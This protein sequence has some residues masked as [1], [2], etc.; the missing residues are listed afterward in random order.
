VKQIS[1][2]PA[3]LAAT[4]FAL[5]CAECGGGTETARAKLGRPANPTTSIGIRQR[6][7]Q[8]AARGDVGSPK[9]YKRSSMV[10]KSYR[11]P[12]AMEQKRKTSSQSWQ[13]AHGKSH[14]R[15]ASGEKLSKRQIAR[16]GFAS[17]YSEGS[18]TASGERFDKHKLN[19][20]H[21]SLPFG[22]HLRVTNVVNGKTVTVRVNDRGPFVHGRIIDVTS[23]A[24]EALGMVN[25]GVVKVTL[26][27]VRQRSGKNV[28]SVPNE[29]RP[30]RKSTTPSAIAS[31]QRMPAKALMHGH[32]AWKALAG[33]PSRPPPSPNASRRVRLVGGEMPSVRNE[34]QHSARRD[35]PL[36]RDPDLEAGGVAQ[37]PVLP[38]G[39]IRAARALTRKHE[40]TPY[41]V[42]NRVQPRPRF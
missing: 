38:Q 25:V 19:A 23:A 4:V 34:G 3:L 29:G 10:T 20:A 15:P 22:T 41:V 7:T 37:V 36:T 16:S 26:D 5:S 17:F 9:T 12:L 24:A 31:A 32:S 14:G 21:R 28:V 39:Q 1:A 8:D 33:P 18:D 30:D 6:T 27:I 42:E 2:K 13:A 35:P 11:R 40:I